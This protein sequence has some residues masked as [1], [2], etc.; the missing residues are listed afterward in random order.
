MNTLNQVAVFDC[1]DMI[2]DGV[3]GLCRDRL[4]R[5]AAGTPESDLRNAAIDALC[6][7]V[8]PLQSRT[9]PYNTLVEK[10]AAI[11]GRSAYEPITH[12][13]PRELANEISTPVGGW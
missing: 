4:P 1:A 10:C 13:Q 7:E 8:F 5:F 11:L 6:W 2:R 12:I 3:T 9:F